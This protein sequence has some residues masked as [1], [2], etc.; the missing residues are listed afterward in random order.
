MRWSIRRSPVAESAFE[1]WLKRCR[2]ELVLGSDVSSPQTSCPDEEFLR[3]LARKSP[4]I[5]LLDP[6]VD[7]VASCQTC[8]RRIGTLQEEVTRYRRRFRL[9]FVVVSLAILAGVV[10]L[11]K[12][13]RVKH[14]GQDE[15]AVLSDTIDLSAAGTYRG[16][17]P[18]QVNPVIL[19]R[20]VVRLTVVLPRFSTG[21]DYLISVTK[22]PAETGSIAAAGAASSGNDIHRTVTVTLDLRSAPLGRHFLSTTREQEQA[23]YYYPVEIR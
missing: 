10:W 19:P 16:D 12:G 11:I 22:G 17:K 18:V 7:H 2:K 14:G 20:G 6:K 13:G 5:D 8:M 23:S 3:S 1:E 9:A 15:V 4:S 21:G